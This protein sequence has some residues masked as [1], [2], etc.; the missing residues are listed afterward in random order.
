[1]ERREALITGVVLAVTSVVIL[2][3]VATGTGPGP[4]VGLASSPAD[5]ADAA[6]AADSAGG[7]GAAESAESAE[8][9]GSSSTGGTLETFVDEAVAFVAATR[10]SSFLTEPDVVVLGERDFVDRVDADLLEDFESHPGQ[11]DVLNAIY[12]ST[13]LIAASDSIEDVYREFG[14]AGILGFYDPSTDELVVR[15][16]DDLSLLT[17][18]TIVHELTHAYDDQNFDLDRPEYDER[19]DEVSWTFRAVAEGSAAWV[20][21]EWEARLTDSER[22]T[23]LAEEFSLGDPSVF[24]RFELS[25]LIYEFSPYEY[26]QPF[27]ESLVEAGGTSALDGVLEDPPVTSEQVILPSRFEDGE[28]GFLLDPPPADGETIF[29]G[30]GGN[31]LIEAL[32]QGN[33]VFRD[34]SWGGD[35]MSVWAAGERSCTRWDVQ[36]ESAGGLVEL[37]AGFEEWAER[38]GTASVTTIDAVTIRVDRCA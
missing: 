31:A 7:D 1:M 6:D 2:M 35:R 14:A 22:S 21:A 19:T 12:R 4:D 24:A 17:R 34:I 28:L 16:V 37:R 9:G 23:L 13:G 11:V 26:G 38:V 33:G 3:I 25:F 29:E 32:F 20:E 15:Q 36:S 27:I 5:A 30:V 8:S 18:S 10:G